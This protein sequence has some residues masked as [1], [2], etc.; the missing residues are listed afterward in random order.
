VNNYKLIIQ[1]DGT[2]YAGWQIQDNAETI[3]GKITEAINTIIK[4]DVTLTGSG[5]TDTGV[6]AL[7]QT[8]NFRTEQELDLFRFTHSLNG[9][10]PRD[11]SI[12]NAEKTDENFHARFDAKR[13]SYVYIITKYKS[14]FYDSYSYFYHSEINCDG[15]NELSKNILGEKDFTSF[16]RK[17]TETKNKI[18]KVYNAAWKETKG[19]IVF[20]IEADRFLHSMVRTIVGTLLNA[21]KNN[22]S[23]DYLKGL[24]SVN[25]REAAAESVPGKGLFLYKVK[26]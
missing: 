2:N 26:Y 21:Q 7:G 12:I 14:P 11:I 3:Q 9:I 6:H 4:E 1:Y 17:N 23:E 8:A 25:D 16:A 24:F 18:C 20:Y 15:L 13:R 19:L 22:L 10:L 5:R